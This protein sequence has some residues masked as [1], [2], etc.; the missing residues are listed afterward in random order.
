MMLQSSHVVAA[1]LLAQ[2]P[3]YGGGAFLSLDQHTFAG[4]AYA[5]GQATA[6]RVRMALPDADGPE[7]SESEAR[8]CTPDMPSAL[9]VFAP[10]QYGRGGGGPGKLTARG[11]AFQW[12][13]E[14]M[15]AFQGQKV[16]E[17]KRKLTK[18]KRPLAE[19]VR[20]VV[21]N[22][23]DQGPGTVLL[24]A[25]FV[26]VTFFDVFFNISRGFICALPGGLCDAVHV[27][28]LDQP[29]L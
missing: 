11:E 9:D 10:S 3:A 24:V 17:A 22:I 23:S 29:V 1:S 26:F 25:F 15:D 4:P 5:C 8:D 12:K 27:G 21:S 2:R 20:T 28:G 18:R 13:D 6:I 16:L 19:R 14:G 7:A